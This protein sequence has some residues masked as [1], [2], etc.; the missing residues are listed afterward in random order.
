LDV[1]LKALAVVADTGG[2]VLAQVKGV[3]S[4][5]H[6]QQ[7]L[8]QANQAL[9]R[10]KPG[11]VGRRK[12]KNRLNRIHVRVGNLRSQASHRLS[13]Q[14]AAGLTSLTV[15]DLNVA[16][17]FANHSLARA[18]SDAGL[19]DL[20]RLLAYKAGW[21]GCRL[22]VADRWYPSSKT[23]SGCGQ[24]K[25]DLTLADRTYRCAACGLLLDQ[26]VNAAINL[27]RWPAQQQHAPPTP[28]AA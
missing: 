16:G 13:K 7:R 18:L 4:L 15:E 27:A 24:L 25:P 1:G 2:V 12:A 14:L 19:A 28:V 11:S 22:T 5:Q 20:G 23:C 3:K 8:R 17:M 10:T 6:A 21:Y 9:A 26:D